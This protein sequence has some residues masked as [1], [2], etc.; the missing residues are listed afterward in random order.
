MKLPV[1]VK[2]GEDFV[3][4]YQGTI[5]GTTKQ[6]IDCRAAAAIVAKYMNDYKPSNFYELNLNLRDPEDAAEFPFSR[7]TKDNMVIFLLGFSFNEKTKYILDELL[8]TNARVL[9][10]TYVDQ[11][12]FENRN[13][14][15]VYGIRARFFGD[16]SSTAYYTA[17]YLMP[18]RVKEL[19]GLHEISDAV[20]TDI[21]DQRSKALIK[22]SLLIYRGLLTVPTNPM[23]PIWRQLFNSNGTADAVIAN[24]ILRGSIITDYLDEKRKAKGVKGVE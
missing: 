3:C 18:D 5:P 24:L 12:G 9:W 17:M 14:L 22:N 6:N 10:F 23:D 1:V 7:I 8:A 4:F 19:C 16:Y 13:E 2:P 21:F 20:T 15:D 11:L